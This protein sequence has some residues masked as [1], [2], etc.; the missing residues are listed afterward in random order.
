MAEGLLL[1]VVQVL[2]PS[3]PVTTD[4]YSNYDNLLADDS[5]MFREINAFC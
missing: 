4:L 2:L 3:F 5:K 1:T